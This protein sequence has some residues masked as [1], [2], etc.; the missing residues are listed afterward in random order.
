MANEI[1]DAR[2]GLANV[3][4][5]SGLRVYE[6]IP[7]AINEVP[8]CIIRLVGGPQYYTL[9]DSFKAQF[10]VTVLT[11]SGDDQE[12]QTELDEYL[13]PNGAMSIKRTVEADQTWGGVVA[14]GYLVRP[15]GD[16]DPG[17]RKWPD[18]TTY[19]AAD[20]R[21]ECMVE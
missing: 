18:G 12:S 20:L 11:R 21:V 10:M 2:R 9:G 4:M 8:C 13:S 6:Y 7:T 19:M 15:G 1:G 5:A 17:P 14:D 3:L 16:T